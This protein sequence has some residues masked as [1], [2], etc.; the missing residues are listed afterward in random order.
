MRAVGF[1]AWRRVSVVVGATDR[2]IKVWNGATLKRSVP[3]HKNRYI[4]LN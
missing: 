1:C 2:T 4:A 3:G